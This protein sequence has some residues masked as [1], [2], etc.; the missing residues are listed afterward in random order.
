[1]KLINYIPDNRQ[2]HFTV[3][4]NFYVYLDQKYVYDVLADCQESSSTGHDNR[5]G[6]AGRW[7]ALWMNYNLQTEVDIKVKRALMEQLVEELIFVSQL[8]W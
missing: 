8:F 2:A 7:I 1:M 6:N 5:F 3:K 4:W